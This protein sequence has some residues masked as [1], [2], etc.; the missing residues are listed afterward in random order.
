[1][2]R[3]QNTTFR[4]RHILNT[5][6]S[7]Y[8]ALT[9]NDGSTRYYQDYPIITD[10]A[11]GG[12]EWHY[13][14]GGKQSPF[15]VV[16]A[17]FDDD[18]FAVNP[19]LYI[20]AG[21]S[22]HSLVDGSPRLYTTNNGWA[23]RGGDEIEIWVQKALTDPAP[24]RIYNGMVV[25]VEP[26][27]GEDQERLLRISGVSYADYW[28]YGRAFGDAAGRDYR[29]TGGPAS[30]IIKQIFNDAKVYFDVTTEENIH[31][32]INRDPE[33]FALD[34]PP[35]AVQHDA[36]IYKEFVGAYC[37]KAMQEVCALVNTEWMIDSAKRLQ[38]AVVGLRTPI[39]ALSLTE[40]YVIGSPKIKWS[41]DG[42]HYDNVVLTA[43]SEMQSPNSTTPTAEAWT[44][45]IKYWF[46]RPVASL[47][48][49]G[50]MRA[51]NEFITHGAMQ[52]GVFTTMQLGWL[53]QASAAT[54]TK[55]A[56][57]AA[58]LASPPAKG[59]T[60]WLSGN[61]VGSWQ[62]LGL[63]EADWDEFRFSFQN[64]FNLSQMYI[65]F[66]DGPNG[67]NGS[68]LS[69]NLVVN[70]EWPAIDAS[71]GVLKRWALKLP[72][73]CNDHPDEV[74]TNWWTPTGSPTKID[75]IQ[76]I[77]IAS[78]VA[79]D[80]DYDHI[81]AAGGGIMPTLLGYT[82]FAKT[83]AAEAAR[84]DQDKRPIPRQLIYID[85]TITNQADAVTLSA[86]ELTR[87]QN[88]TFT[89][90]I[91]VDESYMYLG[92]GFTGVPNLMRCSPGD[93]ITIDI[94]YYGLNA[95]SR[96]VD[97]IVHTVEDNVWLATIGFGTF[98]SDDVFSIWHDRN[99]VYSSGAAKATKPSGAG[100]K[101]G[102]KNWKPSGNTTI[103]HNLSSKVD[104]NMIK[105]LTR[106]KPR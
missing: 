79:S 44:S 49:V 40:N 57:I 25:D 42:Y 35:P 60:E 12:M 28:L 14:S 98:N 15:S 10:N 32:L 97:H 50:E 102:N 103:P 55:S 81:P 87:V 47:S 53:P 43:A 89:G 9:Y 86:A 45:D 91:T 13:A 6:L 3:V 94:D 58:C 20:N 62:G 104:P 33:T 29:T 92:T 54:V 56:T 21:M 67:I 82:H 8:S 100:G 39:Q 106:G 19:S 83:P 1:M 76:F 34:G 72:T 17:V 66:L 2:A 11:Y 77:F 105:R 90:T 71:K 61:A 95:I 38:L 16:L 27:V 51:P 23:I 52:G 80:L 48:S 26:I 30:H 78:A 22:F 93:S 88:T 24:G 75:E 65:N 7:G 68:W 70:S 99:D 41:D 31:A 101:G 84:T 59:I 4:L 37:G 46:L 85:K 74:Y 63:I 18:E 64:S 36:H 69:A 5:A 96:R 73:Y